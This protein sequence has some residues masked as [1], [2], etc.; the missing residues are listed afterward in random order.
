MISHTEQALPKVS[1]VKRGLRAL[2]HSTI[3]NAT[4]DERLNA[5]RYKGASVAFMVSYILTFAVLIVMEFVDAP[6]RVSY[7]T[8]LMIHLLGGCFANMIYL[9]IKRYPEAVQE[10]LTRSSDGRKIARNSVIFQSLLSS[11]FYYAGLRLFPG[12]LDTKGGVTDI[13]ISLTMGLWVGLVMWWDLA[14]SRKKN[15]AARENGKV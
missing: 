15:A 4:K 13:V 12:F 5:I 14:R 9:W 2:F 6:E 8:L 1:K 11:I 3:G 7:K 10:M